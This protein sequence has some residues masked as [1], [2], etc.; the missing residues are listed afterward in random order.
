MREWCERKKR[1]F[2]EK[3]NQAAY[4]HTIYLSTKRAISEIKNRVPM[5]RFFCFI[6]VTHSMLG[7][8][9]SRQISFARAHLDFSSQAIKD[10]NDEDDC[11]GDDDARLC[12]LFRHTLTLLHENQRRERKKKLFT[13]DI[14]PLEAITLKLAC[15]S[16]TA[17]AKDEVRECIERG[18]HEAQN[19]HSKRKGKCTQQ[20][21]CI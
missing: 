14:L 1:R 2:D 15:S 8:C 4:T 18:E 16:K 11:D 13:A 21:I 9:L 17:S 19:T 20:T 5:L 6:C 7:K 3:S 10:D 12:R